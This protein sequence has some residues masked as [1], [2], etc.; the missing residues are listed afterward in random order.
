ME[1]GRQGV[2][3]V[4]TQIQAFNSGK[5]LKEGMGGTL[6]RKEGWVF[7]SSS[8][9]GASAPV[10]QQKRQQNCGKAAAAPAAAAAA[11]YRGGFRQNS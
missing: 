3:E 9:S 7:R 11:A 4:L 8:S 5:H 2:G 6:A 10:D 1:R